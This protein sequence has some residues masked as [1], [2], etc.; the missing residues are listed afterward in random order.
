MDQDSW[1]VVRVRIGRGNA[2]V[3]DEDADRDDVIRYLRKMAEIL[4]K[5]AQPETKPWFLFHVNTSIMEAMSVVS[6]SFM[7]LQTRFC[8]EY[9]QRLQALSSGFVVVIESSFMRGI[10]SKL[11]AM[12][13]TNL[14]LVYCGSLD[15]AEASL[16]RLCASEKSLPDV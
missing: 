10:A 11:T 15:E 6:G 16:K 2:D 4:N 12:F 9:Y 14:P 13:P 3:R 5:R 1:P 8:K 7:T